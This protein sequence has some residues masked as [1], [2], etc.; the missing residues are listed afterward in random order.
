M[1]LFSEIELFI[2]AGNRVPISKYKDIYT[3]LEN[4]NKRLQ[5]QQQ[6]MEHEIET[7]KNEIL[8]MEKR[9]EE[10]N[11]KFGKRKIETED[12]QNV[13]TQSKRIK[14]EDRNCLRTDTNDDNMIDSTG[15][16]AVSIQD[17][18]LSNSDPLP[19]AYIDYDRNLL[20]DKKLTQFAGMSI[21]MRKLMNKKTTFQDET[22]EAINVKGLYAKINR[23]YPIPYIPQKCENLEYNITN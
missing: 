20:L 13:N 21:T 12:E 1:H 17:P 3:E 18:Q 8:Y 15:T 19:Y 11:S 4:N 10:N 2:F 7:L 16:D 23:I 5:Y 14:L 6:Q 22:P 9:L